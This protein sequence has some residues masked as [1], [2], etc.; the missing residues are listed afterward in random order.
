MLW[1]PPAEVKEAQRRIKE[2][3]A[4]I[5]RLLLAESQAPPGERPAIR[6]RINQLTQELYRQYEVMAEY[7]AY[8]MVPAMLPVKAKAPGAP[9]KPK[10][11]R[12]MSLRQLLGYMAQLMKRLGKGTAAAGATTWDKIKAA[13]GWLTN[14]AQTA[15]LLIF[16]G[17]E[18]KQMKMWMDAQ[19]LESQTEREK[20]ASYE[21]RQAMERERLQLDWAKYW[22]DYAKF[23]RDAQRLSG[24]GRAR[25]EAYRRAKAVDP[26]LRAALEMQVN[27]AK[28]RSAAMWQD[29]ERAR[30]HAREVALETLKKQWEWAIEAGKIY[31]QNWLDEQ[32]KIREAALEQFKAQLKAQ[33][34]GIETSAEIAKEM[35]KAE[36]EMR[37]AITKEMA[38]MKRELAV[39]RLK[40]L[41]EM[42]LERQKSLQIL[43]EAA[44]DLNK[45]QKEAIME[46][47]RTAKEAIKQGKDAKDILRVAVDMLQNPEK[48]RERLQVKEVI[49]QKW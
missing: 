5:D 23:M 47:I 37:V 27:E 3:E 13:G 14:L 26:Q 21:K 39:E 18:I 25:Q 34:I 31:G 36:A 44:R 6:N 28:A 11:R 4:E 30:Q 15:G 12:P 2:L 8:N 1:E 19:K 41:I 45:Q 48:Y 32:K 46:L 7:T 42:D 9:G 22:L 40:G 24:Y 43:Q 29:W 20:I 35:R 38:R 17:M 16:G 49:V 10:M 33:L